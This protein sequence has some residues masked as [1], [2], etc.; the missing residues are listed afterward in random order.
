MY[1]HTF[2]SLAILYN[3]KESSQMP[4]PPPAAQCRLH[5]NLVIQTILH[6]YDTASLSAH[7]ILNFRRKKF[8]TL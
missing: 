8:S 3:L 6:G 4:N 5:N 7:R 1:T 2:L